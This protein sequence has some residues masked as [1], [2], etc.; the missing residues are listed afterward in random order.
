M[1]SFLLLL[2]VLSSCFSVNSSGQ[3]LNQLRLLEKHKYEQ[4]SLSKQ[5]AAPLS[6]QKFRLNRLSVYNDT[7]DECDINLDNSILLKDV[8]II[9]AGD[10]L[11]TITKLNVDRKFEISQIKS[12]KFINHG[13]SKGLIYGVL[14]STAFW[15]ILGTATSSAWGK[16]GVWFLIGFV[17]GIPTGIITG[18]IT[19]FATQDDIYDFGNINNAAKLSRLKYIMREHKN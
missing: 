3:E 1:K 13:F 14:A 18:I 15:G 9:D 16:S 6:I 12:I 17:L 4:S 7:T 8:K 10:S 11:F 2:M 19:E 5:I